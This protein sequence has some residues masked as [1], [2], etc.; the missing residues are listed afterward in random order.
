MLD[1]ISTDV[2]NDRLFINTQFFVFFK[3]KYIRK[4]IQNNL[5][6][7]ETLAKLRN[8]KKYELMEAI[9][10]HR[11]LS[12]GVGDMKSRINRFKATFRVKLNNWWAHNSLK[13]A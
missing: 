4:Q 8:S 10:Q 13:T 7:D 11:V 12:D 6:R 2:S 1:K 9:Y 3:E 5:S